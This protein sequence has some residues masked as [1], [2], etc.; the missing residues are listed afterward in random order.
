MNVIPVRTRVFREGEDLVAFIVRYVPRLREGAVLAITSKIVALSEGRTARMEDKAKVI[1]AESEWAMRTKY[2]WLAEKDGM[3][4]A[5]AGVDESNADGKLILLPEDSFKAAKHL[6]EALRRHYRL[7]TL[8]IL[9]TDSRVLPLRAGVVGVA[10]GYAGIKGLRDYR[11]SQDIFGR[12]L[13]FTQTNVAD[14]LASAAVVAMGEGKERQPL[15]VITDAPVAFT[16]RMDRH[17]LR[18]L[19]EDDMY[20]P[21][22]KTRSRASARR[23]KR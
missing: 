3:L 21:L 17:E 15:A 22:F 11:G 4:L 2:V 1:R 9:I 5:N 13:H 6:L 20:A 12:K 16:A 23:K 10:L 14:S 8:G 18:I 19:P 7:K